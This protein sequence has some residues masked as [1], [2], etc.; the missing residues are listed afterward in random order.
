MARITEFFKAASNASA[1]PTN[2][3][4]GW[5]VVLT[6]GGSILQLSTFGSD[7]RAS[8]KKVSQTLQLDRAAAA[9]LLGI[10]HQVFPDLTTK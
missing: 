10:L 3:E 2:V 4:C 7:S 6:Q 9:E 1:H 5:Q 8:E